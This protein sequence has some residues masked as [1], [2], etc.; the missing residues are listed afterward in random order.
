[1]LLTF[2]L[3][4]EC[5]LFF[6]L[7]CSSVKKAAT[8]I[9]HWLVSPSRLFR[10]TKLGLKSMAPSA[11]NNLE[12]PSSWLAGG[13][14]QPSQ[15]T[16]FCQ[17]QRSAWPILNIPSRAYPVCISPTRVSSCALASRYV[18]F[19]ALSKTKYRPCKLRIQSLDLATIE[20]D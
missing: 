8:A 14:A 10:N 13:P 1:M 2:E 18:C 17:T 3:D 5:C 19:N 6:C 4:S 12:A 9:A 16:C 15:P 7:R 11:G 20:Y